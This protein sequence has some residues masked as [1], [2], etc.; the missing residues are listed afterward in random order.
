[1]ANSLPKEVATA[2]TRQDGHHLIILSKDDDSTDYVKTGD[3]SRST[4]SYPGWIKV[5]KKMNNSKYWET[6]KQEKD[7]FL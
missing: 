3:W 7:Y 5:R 2:G 6:K 4:Y 1:M